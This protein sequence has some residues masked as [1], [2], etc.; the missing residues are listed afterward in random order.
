MDALKNAFGSSNSTQPT[1]TEQ[2]AQQQSGGGGL[3]GSV[4]NA[5]GGGAQGEKNEDYLDKGAFCFLLLE[6]FGD[7]KRVRLGDE[8]WVEIASTAVE[9]TTSTPPRSRSL[10]L[11]DPRQTPTDHP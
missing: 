2:P 1:S 6:G 4:N 9:H 7:G 8:R 5:L 10:S 11:P 3:F